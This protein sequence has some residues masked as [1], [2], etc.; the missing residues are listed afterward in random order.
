MVS[1]RSSA[2]FVKFEEVIND[3]DDTVNNKL[4]TLSMLCSGD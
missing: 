2:S 3:M 4:L 1:S